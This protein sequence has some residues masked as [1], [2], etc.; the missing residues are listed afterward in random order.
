[1]NSI[2]ATER[3]LIGATSDEVVVDDIDRLELDGSVEVTVSATDEPS[4]NKAKQQQER[5]LESNGIF[6]VEDSSSI[7]N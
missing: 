3:N 2:E 6:E 1:M 5:W 7:V 4:P